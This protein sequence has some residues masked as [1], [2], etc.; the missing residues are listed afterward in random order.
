MSSDS[1]MGTPQYIS[2]EQAMGKKDL[3]AGTDIYS[4][5]VMLY[6]MVVGQVPFSADTP[7]SVIHD[8]IY[9]PLPLPRKVNPNV[10][11]SVQRVLLKALAKDRLD[12]YVLTEELVTAFKEAWTEAGMP[13]QGTAI[14]MRS[15]A[16]KDGAASKKPPVIPDEKTAVA[17]TPVKKRSPWMWASIG[18]I[19]LLCLTVMGLAVRNRI[20]HQLAPPAMKTPAPATQ[21]FPASPLPEPGNGVPGEQQSLP[22]VQNASPELV[23]AM[24]TAAKHPNDFDAHL[25]LSIALLE[26]KEFR[27]AMVELEKAV[28]LAGPNNR[29]FF[30]NAAEKF[31]EREAWGV[32]AGL[33]L[34]TASTYRNESVPRELEDRIHEAVYKAAEQKDLQSIDLFERVEVFSPAL[35]H[36]ARGRHALYQGNFEETKAQMANAEKIIPNMPEA[37]MLKAEIEMKMGNMKEA[38]DTLL[39]LPPDPETPEWIRIM[40]ENYLKIIQ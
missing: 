9:T 20:N 22:T 31:A 23:A 21:V 19:I 28:E 13:M 16:A 32:A 25:G 34:R 26:A 6:E 29:D 38:K 1:I 5:G 12:R 14:V 2:P 30:L 37:K 17:Q 4:F 27:P 8:H 40:A 35:G 36:V 39:A 33:Y 11:E 7:F 24:D 3:D 10:P 18:L 15:T